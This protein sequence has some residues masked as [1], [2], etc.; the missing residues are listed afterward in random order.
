LAHAMQH[1]QEK[2]PDLTISLNSRRSALKIDSKDRIYT[3]HTRWHSLYSS[4]TLAARF[5]VKS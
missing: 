1:L 4:A 2:L 5:Y 3:L